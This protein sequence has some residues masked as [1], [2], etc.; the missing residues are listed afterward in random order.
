MP[1]RGEQRLLD[2]MA[3]QFGARQLARVQVTPF[4]QP[5]ARLRLVAALQ[6]VADVGEV[7]T[8][9][10][11]AERDVEDEHAPRQRQHAVQVRQGK[12]DAPDGE[13]GRE[14][15]HAPHHPRVPLAAGVEVASAPAHP[16]HQHLVHPVAARQ[17]LELLGEERQQHGK[18]THGR[19]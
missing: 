6:R 8:E 18:K 15:G 1:V 3:Q 17:G 4:G 16:R 10:P 2:H 12:M 14:C 13:R 11:K 7:V 9:L 19:R 5:L